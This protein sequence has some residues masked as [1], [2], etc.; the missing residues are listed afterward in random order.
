MRLAAGPIKQFHNG[1]LTLCWNWPIREAKLSHMTDLICLFQHLVKST[2]DFLKD[3][4][5]ATFAFPL[6]KLQMLKEKNKAA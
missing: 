1:I 6:S 5:Q 4:V 2:P 3:Q